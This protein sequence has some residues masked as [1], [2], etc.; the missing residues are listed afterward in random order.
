MGP[1]LFAVV[2]FEYVGG[3]LDQCGLSF[4]HPFR[5]ICFLY[6]YY[7]YYYTLL[8]VFNASVC[9]WFFTGIQVAASLQDSSQYSGWS[10]QCYSLDDLHSFSY[11]Q[12]LQSLYY[13]CG[14]CAE[15]ANYA[16]ILIKK[17]KK[18]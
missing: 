9:W 12:V 13:S 14:D 5:Y 11:L 10:Q 7:Y 2:P 1:Q 17:K 8:R 15:R 4:G 3:I 16:I 18:K 6:Y